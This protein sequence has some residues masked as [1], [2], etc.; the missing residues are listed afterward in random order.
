MLAGSSLP[1]VGG[2]PTRHTHDIMYTYELVFIIYTSTPQMTKNTH[3]V[4]ATTIRII[5]RSLTYAWA[6]TRR[7]LICR[8]EACTQPER[9][10]REELRAWATIEG[11]GTITF[12]W[13]VPC[14]VRLKPNA[15]HTWIVQ[16][17]SPQQ[18]LVPCA[19]SHTRAV[20]A[21][22]HSCHD[23]LRRKL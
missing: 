10:R 14:T 3:T 11:D 7:P 16:V 15:R 9:V 5:R 8:N 6:S 12:G 18:Q 2:A 17:A 23:Q 13:H 19:S 4:Y 1:R 22:D 21:N 20:S